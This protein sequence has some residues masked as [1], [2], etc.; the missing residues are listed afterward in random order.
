MNTSSWPV[1]DLFFRA[2][3][4]FCEAL[5][6]ATGT[7]CCSESSHTDAMMP[8]RLRHHNF[9][10]NTRP[11]TESKLSVVAVRFISS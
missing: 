3:I 9:D 11:D 7:Y 4:F 8:S 5:A 1:R 2:E 10:M 6:V